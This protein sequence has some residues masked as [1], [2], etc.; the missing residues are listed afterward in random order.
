MTRG[1]PTPGASVLRTA[2]LPALVMMGV[3]LATASR[4]DLH[5]DELYFRMLPVAWWYEDQP[6]L[7]VWL[8]QVAQDASHAVWV[9]R[10]PAI[11]AAGAGTVL[12]AMFPRVLG[13]GDDVQRVAAWAH[14]TTV[15]P[16]L[17]GHVFLTSSLDLVAWQAVVLLVLVAVRGQPAALTWAGV[18]AGLACWNKLLVVVLVAAAF[19][20]LA[21]A[22]PRVLR[23]RHTVFGA[24]AM[25]VIALPQVGA[26]LV[27][28]MP[29]SSVSGSL[30]ERQG[31]LNRLLVLPLLVAFLGPPLAGVWWRGLWWRPSR[32]AAAPDDGSDTSPGG[33]P[34]PAGG[35]WSVL[36]VT[37]ALVTLWTLLFPAQPYYFVAAFLPA[38]AVGWH[39]ARFDGARVWRSARPIIAANAAVA[40]VLC[41]PV[42]PTDSR[43][44]AVVAAANPV[45]RDQAGWRGYVEQVAAARGADAAVVTHTYALAGAIAY[46]GE[47]AGIPRDRVASGH[48]ALWSLG[49]P[50]ADSVLLVGDI[51]TTHRGYFRRCEDAGVLHRTESDPFRT[52]GSRMARCVGPV[53]GWA[54][55]WPAFRRLG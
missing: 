9:Q 33:A 18:V 12:A 19:V 55:V 49:P 1:G 6:P 37:A 53:G 35:P 17:V 2:G 4:Y 30:I 16:L 5:G 24:V 23:T 29:M 7:T 27:H 51:A 10:V 20:G 54:H 48:N 31:D 21:V 25:G 13:H 3:L 44:Y 26:Q 15:Y 42:L 22:H 40:A 36:G 14:A 11:L 47:Q 52:A 8:T 45:A 41:L 38:L 43:A 34:R 28:G 46:H 39:R 32:G 50:A